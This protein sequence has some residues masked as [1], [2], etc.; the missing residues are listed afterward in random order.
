MESQQSDPGDL[1]GGSR[2]VD[3]S[4]DSGAESTAVGRGGEEHDETVAADT[5]NTVADRSGSP[6]AVAVKQ[7][8]P[9]GKDAK[10]RAQAIAPC[11]PDSGDTEVKARNDEPGC[12][13]GN[14][15]GVVS[16]G[17]D[18]GWFSRWPSGAVAAGAALFVGCAAYAG[19][20]VQPYLVDRAMDATKMEIARTAT[21]AVTTLWTYTPDTIDSLPDRAAS[22]LSGD[23]EAQYRKL[24]GALVTPNKQAQI[25]DT[26]D[27]VGVAVESLTASQATV[28]VFTN[29][30]STSPMT[31][32]VPSLKFIG[33]RMDMTQQGSRW[34]VTKMA[35]VTFVDLTPKL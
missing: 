27:V 32:N 11:D 17:E 3:G 12:T 34:L 35:T 23:L 15:V 31:K 2:G 6:S 10:R 18:R 20:A 7:H 8:R 13:S 24:A 22:Y 30:T 28:M 25:T 1:I 29:T 9:I 19:A 14:D 4:S 26:T 21:A 16:T 5:E 33:Y